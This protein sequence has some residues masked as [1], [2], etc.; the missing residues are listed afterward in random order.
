ML[1]LSY[2]ETE[3]AALATLSTLDHPRDDYLDYVLGETIDTLKPYWLPGLESGNTYGQQEPAHIQYLLS[4]LDNE[5][6]TELPRIPAVTRALVLRN[7]TEL[8]VL[9]VVLSDHVAA[10]DG[11]PAETLVALL[12]EAD[13]LERE[14]PLAVISDALLDQP[15]S[16][17]SAQASALQE[18]ARTSHLPETGEWATAILLS[19]SPETVDL[20]TEPTSRNNDVARTNRLLGALTRV[21]PEVRQ[22]YFDQVN[23]L[24][25]Q[26]PRSLLNDPESAAETRRRAIAAL[27]LMPEREQEGFAT[28]AGLLSDP[29]LAGAALDALATT[30][31]YDPA[32]TATP[33][34]GAELASALRR[35][36][37]QVAIEQLTS[38]NVRAWFDLGNRL[39]ARAG[40]SSLSALDT[41]LAERAI[42][43]ITIRPVPHQMVFDTLELTVEAER[44]VELRLVNTDIMPHNLVVTAP[45]GLEDVG[46]MA[47]AMARD[48]PARAEARHYIPSF[49]NLVLFATPLVH[50]GDSAALAFRRAK[51]SGQVSL[52]LYFPR[53]LDS[54]ER[55][56]ERR[57][58]GLA[59]R[60][61]RPSSWRRRTHNRR[62]RRFEQ[63]RVRRGLD[64]RTATTSGREFG[65]GPLGDPSPDRERTRAVH[66]HRLRQVS[67]DEPARRAYRPGAR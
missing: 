9:R 3:A 67:S 63:S 21:Q 18:L 39:V 28:L 26:L 24:S 50:P 12:V 56:H 64:T 51:D 11:T 46:E 47:E 10:A 29:E 49:N 36:I 59:G 1:A 31:S 53:P 55:N 22:R 48:N 4:R 43:E 19:S 40:N 60:P 15:P 41:V 45:G 62:F 13:A 30:T 42:R 66:I 5:T 17:L 37:D 44:P 58:L 38:A 32:D 27:A 65:A 23:A 34:D 16:R 54:H 8:P 61:S 52:R 6:L 35:E 57:A 20:V 2:L 33:D 7:D 14:E 25:Q